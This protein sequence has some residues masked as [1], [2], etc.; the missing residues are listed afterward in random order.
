[1][2]TVMYWL[3]LA[4]CFPLQAEDLPNFPSEKKASPHKLFVSSENTTQNDESFKIDSGYSYNVF[5]KID[6]YVGARIDNSEVDGEKK[7]VNGLLSG[8][9][10]QVTESITVKSTLRS[11]TETVYEDN[12]TSVAAEVSSRMK[13]SENLDVHA[14][15]DYQEWRQGIEVGIGFRF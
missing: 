2:K 13:L 11:Y 10:Y 14:T 7:M 4:I 1:M 3:P 15:L 12:V 5:N 6:L 8:L 9:S